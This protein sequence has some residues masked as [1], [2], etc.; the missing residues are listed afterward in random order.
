MP[1]GTN[2][3]AETGSS[4][5]PSEMV[6]VLDFGGQYNQLICRR[7]RECGVYS[8]LLPADLPVEKLRDLP[9]KGLILSGGPKSIYAKD[10]LSPDPSLWELDLPILGI[11]Y[12]LQLMAHHYGGKVVGGEHAEYGPA[13]LHVTHGG[14]LFSDWSAEEPVW[15]SHGDRVLVAPPGFVVDAQTQETPIAAMHDAQRKRYAVQFHPE[16]SQT[17]K[18]M[19]LIRRFLMDICHCQGEWRLEDVVQRLVEQVR[20][21][22]GRDGEA[23]CALSGGVDSAVAAAVAGRALGNRLHCIFVDH[24]LLREGE[25]DQ[26]LESFAQLHIEVHYVDARERFLHLLE[27]VVDPEE[28]RKRIGAAFIRTFEVEARRWGEVPFLVQGT[29]YPDVIESGSGAS[30]TIKSHHNV[31]GLPEDLQFTLVEPLRW[32]FKDEV[33][34]VGLLL[35]LPETLVWRQPFP[36]PG[37]AIRI[38]GAVTPQRLQL[39]RRADAIVRKEIEASGY[40]RQL[41]QYFAVLPGIRSVGVKGD[42][43][44]YGETIAIRA[45]RSQ[46][47]M[48]AEWAPL[49]PALLA[50]IAQRLCNE[51]PEVNR[52]VYDITTKPPATVEW[53]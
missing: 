42:V 1:K 8:E 23:I 36:G 45:V 18:G 38:I 29:L 32:L 4:L 9:L 26:V 27:G 51:L 30:A 41:W 2:D 25:A 24:G 43:R 28:K 52:V 47:G 49:P 35:G 6:A 11:C 37:L 16:V 46:D 34:Q 22:V 7:V 31:G 33:R 12:G 50:K 20:A 14:P 5:V 3:Q 10:A 44:T 17:P 40:Q 48:T 21:Q 13:T 19:Q 53:E 39:V 15:M